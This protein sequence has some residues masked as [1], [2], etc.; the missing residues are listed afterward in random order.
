MASRDA[1]HL[2]LSL[3]HVETDETYLPTWRDR[4]QSSPYHG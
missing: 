1:Q 4:E 2:T 3:L